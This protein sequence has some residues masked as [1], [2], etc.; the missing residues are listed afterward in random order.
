M[1]TNVQYSSLIKLYGL[2][3]A[4]KSWYE[5]INQTLFQF[6]FMS[7]KCDQSLFIYNH[8]GITLYALVYVDDILI[9]WS[10]STLIHKLTCKLHD[11]FTFK[12]IGKLEYFL[13]IKV[14]YQADGYLLLTQT[15][16]IKDIISKVNMEEVN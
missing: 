11:K 5:K 13:D 14:K 12:N 15:K 4:P 16:Y 7:S 6:G 10:S 1:T 3:K 2:K 9:T 8:Q